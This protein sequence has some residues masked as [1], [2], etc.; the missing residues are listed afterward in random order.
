MSVQ[1]EPVA[2]G[3]SAPSSASQPSTAFTPGPWAVST[4]DGA[5]VLVGPQKIASAYHGNQ[6]GG[7]FEAEANA[8]LMA[9]APELLEVARE[10]KELFRFAL[11]STSPAIARDGMEFIRKAEAA[12]A[13]ALAGQ[14]VTTS[15]DGALAPHTAGAGGPQ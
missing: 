12:I 10:L 8:R 7:W 4:T 9:A 15:D 2:S 5:L 3:A 6:G 13:K 1:N 14:E 11:L